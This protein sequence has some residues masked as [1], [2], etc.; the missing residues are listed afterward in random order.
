MERVFPSPSLLTFLIP[1]P[2]YLPLFSSHT[3]ISFAPI[4]SLSI[5]LSLFLSAYLYFTPFSHS[6]YLST[7]PFPPPPTFLHQSTQP[8]PLSPLSSHPWH[9]IHSQLCSAP[10]LPSTLNIRSP[11]PVLPSPPTSHSWLSIDL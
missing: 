9:F 4:P 7:H 3:L 1:L 2:N 11:E 6:L 5:C 10:H 8:L